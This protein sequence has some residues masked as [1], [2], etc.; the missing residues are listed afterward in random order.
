MIKFTKND[1]Y[2]VIVKMFVY[3]EPEKY[4]K[5][6]DSVYADAR[7]TGNYKGF[8]QFTA[9]ADAA[10]VAYVHLL[11]LVST[12]LIDGEDT[13]VVRKHMMA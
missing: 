11:E 5:L 12:G 8:E 10:M 4:I 9:Y 1:V 13:N 3:G 2:D 6:R 7:K